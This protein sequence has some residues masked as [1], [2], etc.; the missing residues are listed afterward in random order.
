MPAAEVDLWLTKG[1]VGVLGTRAGRPLGLEAVEEAVVVEGV[2]MRRGVL[3][4][5]ATLGEAAVGVFGTRTFFSISTDKRK[6]SKEY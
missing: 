2:L 6:E 1:V 4:L 5:L 3:R